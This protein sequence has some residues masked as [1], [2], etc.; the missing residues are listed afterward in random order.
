MNTAYTP[1][2][3]RAAVA[4]MRVMVARANGLRTKHACSIPGRW[5]SSTKVPRPVS[6]RLS[7]TR[8][9]RVPEY[10]VA[11]VSVIGDRSIP[12]ECFCA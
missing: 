7:S 12:S 6:R 1:G 2:I 10:R 5:M 9:T 11:T 3:A 4:S 8:A